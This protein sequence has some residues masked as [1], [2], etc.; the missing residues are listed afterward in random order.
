MTA[1]RAISQLPHKFGLSYDEIHIDVPCELDE[2]YEMLIAKYA[3]IF[4]ISEYKF[5][6]YAIYKTETGG[7]S[8][9]L[10]EDNNYGGLKSSTGPGFDKQANRHLGAIEFIA[11]LKYV[12]IDNGLNTPL[13]IQPVYAPSF[14]NDG[15]QWVAN[16]E[17][18]MIN[19]ESIYETINEQLAM[20]SK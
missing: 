5:L 12:Y 1:V 20:R 19:A 4:G 3:D 11:T 14:E 2:S 8:R 7:N 9:L 18:N 10:V 15:E 13:E 6:A 17:W 16:V